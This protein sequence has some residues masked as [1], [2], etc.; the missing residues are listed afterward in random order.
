MLRK[1]RQLYQLEAVPD[2]V[3]DLHS[4]TGTSSPTRRPKEGPKLRLKSVF[5]SITS[6]YLH[7]ELVLRLD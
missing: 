7:E 3:S 5:L 4:P 1:L 2:I 6:T